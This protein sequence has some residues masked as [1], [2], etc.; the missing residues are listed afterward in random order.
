MSAFH[1]LWPIDN[2]VINANTGGRIN[3]NV[4]Y[5]GAENNVA[6]LQAIDETKQ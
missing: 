6:P 3:Q 5:F 1:V 2:N 4:G